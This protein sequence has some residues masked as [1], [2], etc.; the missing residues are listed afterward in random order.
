MQL[1]L[2]QF[3]RCVS[4]FAASL[5]VNFVPLIIYQYG[6]L[7]WSKTFSMGLAFGYLVISSL[8]VAFFSWLLRKHLYSK[9]QVFLCLRIIPMVAMLIFV[10]FLN[11]NSIWIMLCVAISSAFNT[12]FSAIPQEAIYNFV[13]VD[14]NSNALGITR[15]LSQVGYVLAGIV[16]GLF[17]D[18]INE[19][20]VVIVSLVLYIISSLPLLIYY[21]KN[22]KKQG[23]NTESIATIVQNVDASTT[24]Q[25]IRKKFLKENFFAYLLIGVTD[26][27]YD[28]FSILLFVSTDSYFV[29]GI[30][31]GIYDALYAIMCLLAGYLLQKHD[32]KWLSFSA[33]LIMAAAWI[34]CILCD[35]IWL[36]CLLFLSNAFVQPFF[37]LYMFQMFLD[38]ARI[39]G[40]SNRQL[41]DYNNACFCS[42]SIADSFGLIGSYIPSIICGIVFAVLGAFNLL[43][44]ERKTTKDLVEF[45]NQNDIID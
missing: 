17:L 28:F 26:Q 24:T 15:F 19:V 35:I 3:Y 18:K 22:H 1:K 2:L 11:T 25:I 10:A 36:R 29:A 40:V 32:G 20:F 33:I 21:I 43:R 16:G 5:I 34:P 44:A 12:V 14:K 9:P 42:Y 38:K 7:K 23:F 37:N 6:I 39:L 4:T 8:L 45:L 30:V 27:F 31:L 13:S 41:L